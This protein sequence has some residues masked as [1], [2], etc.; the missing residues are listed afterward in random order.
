VAGHSFFLSE[1]KMNST[2]WKFPL[3][4]TDE[5]TVEF[6][7]GAEILSVQAQDN[8]PCVWALVNPKGKKMPKTFHIFG[9]GHNVPPAE[10]KFIGTYQLHGGALV[11]HL[12]EAL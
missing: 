9:T 7:E 11:F 4:T 2:I 1:V 12:F 6:P 3:K 5:Q 10:R 8:T